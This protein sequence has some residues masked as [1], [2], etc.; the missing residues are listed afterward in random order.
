[1]PRTRKQPDKNLLLQIA[2][3]KGREG[4][5]NGEIAAKLRI[6]ARSVTPLINETIKWLLAE[7]QRLTRLDRPDKEQRLLEQKLKMKFPCLKRVQIVRGPEIATERAYAGLIQQWGPIGASYLDRLGDDA[8]REGKELHVAMSGG[9]TI[10]EVVN[11]LPERTRANMYFHASAAIGRGAIRYKSHID[12]AVN[13]TVAWA[14]SG[15]I[16]QRCSYATASPYDLTGDARYSH[17]GKRR[18]IFR[19]RATLSETPSIREYFEKDMDCIDVAFA[20]IGLVSPPK[21]APGLSNRVTGA[22]LLKATTHIEPGDIAREG[23]IGDIAYCF[24]DADGRGDDDK[25]RFFPTAGDHDPK[26]RGVAFY[27][28]MVEERKPVIVIEG[29]YKVPA[30]VAALKGRL[31]NVWI[32]DEAAARQ[33]LA[34]N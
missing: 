29:S 18:E 30:I 20:G 28:R 15:R 3:L 13:V 16:P 4:R 9:E 5:N 19:Q 34:A 12:P 21:G 2:K 6:G 23:A 24:F 33:A 22:E 27:R 32:T 10:L 11:S 26:R 8:A 31:F 7:Q 17:D 14:R 25:W 1:V